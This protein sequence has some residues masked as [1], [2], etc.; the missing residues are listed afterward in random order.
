M[1]LFLDIKS[2]LRIRYANV[3]TEK[4]VS[5]DLVKI[6]NSDAK[7]KAAPLATQIPSAKG[8]TDKK[9]YRLAQLM[10]AENDD[11]V[12]LTGIVAVK[13]MKSEKYPN[14]LE[15]VISQ[16]GQYSTYQTGRIDCEPDERCLEIAEEILR[17]NL[18][19][20]N[21]CYGCCSLPLHQQMIR[22]Q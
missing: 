21:C 12:L 10:Y 18:L 11:Y 4:P 22:R 1:V 19:V 3:S 2:Y 9:I 14:T 17:F 5:I 20:F 8:V 6:Q 13:R 7:P 16:E 15:G